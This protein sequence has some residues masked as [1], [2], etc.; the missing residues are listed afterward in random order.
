MPPHSSARSP[1]VLVLDLL[2]FGPIRAE[3]RALVHDQLGT[4]VA[5]RARAQ[6]LERTIVARLL[7]P[8][9]QT[10]AANGSSDPNEDVACIDGARL[11]PRSVLSSDRCLNTGM[12]T[13]ECRDALSSS[14][15]G[16][17]AKS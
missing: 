7:P 5:L 15:M 1:L 17:Q 13:K 12:R 16:G 8:R 9:E 11:P 2:L 14:R 10:A 6:Q 3:E 4:T